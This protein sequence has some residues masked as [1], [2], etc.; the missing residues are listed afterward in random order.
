MGGTCGGRRENVR[1]DFQISAQHWVGGGIF[2]GRGI[3]WG[4]DH[5]DSG[6]RWVGL[7]L[8]VPWGVDVQGALTSGPRVLESWCQRQ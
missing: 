2:T 7:G 3:G 1:N 5:T 6:L 8:G 4:E